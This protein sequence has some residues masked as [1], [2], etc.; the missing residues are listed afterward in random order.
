LA[1]TSVPRALAPHPLHEGLQL[2][3]EAGGTSSTAFGIGEIKRFGISPCPSLKR[4]DFV[5]EQ[6]SPK[7]SHQSTSS[8]SIAY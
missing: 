6:V 7:K 4:D 2:P 3:L 1:S 5:S 8:T